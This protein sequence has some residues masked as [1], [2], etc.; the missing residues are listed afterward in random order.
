MDAL[1]QRFCSCC[2]RLQTGRNVSVVNSE[3]D[4]ILVDPNCWEMCMSVVCNPAA[5]P[6]PHRVYH[7]YIAA[8]MLHLLTARSWT[9]LPSDLRIRVKTVCV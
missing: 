7:V 3:I 9:Q 8:K 4:E 6:P 2:H 5:L 1:Y